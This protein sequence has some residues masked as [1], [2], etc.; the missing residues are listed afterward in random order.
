MT[1]SPPILILSRATRQA[2]PM[3]WLAGSQT[4]DLELEFDVPALKWDTQKLLA[5]LIVIVMDLWATSGRSL[6]PASPYYSGGHHPISVSHGMSAWHWRVPLPAQAGINEDNLASFVHDLAARLV[7]RANTLCALDF[8][9]AGTLEATRLGVTTPGPHN[10]FGTMPTTTVAQ[11]LAAIAT[12]QTA[13][14]TEIDR[15]LALDA[16]AGTQRHSDLVRALHIER[17]P[18]EYGLAR[19]ILLSA[20]TTKG[21]TIGLR[22]HSLPCFGSVLAVD[23]KA[24]GSAL[25]SDGW[26][27]NFGWDN[28]R[29]S[30][31]AGRGEK[32]RK[33]CA[34]DLLA[35]WW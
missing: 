17:S 12:M 29:P 3:Y 32:L 27:E 21:K 19:R 20:P 10:P 2:K 1:K 5:D 4:G 18:L 22:D 28:S 9:V 30:W 34:R 31:I 24:A 14:A 13:W 26:I 15:Y 7:T 25:M 11:T 6:R 33:L 8:A 23:M 35:L 16:A